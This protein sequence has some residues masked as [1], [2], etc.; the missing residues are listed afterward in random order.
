[1]RE[2]LVGVSALESGGPSVLK[3]TLDIVMD[4]D[5]AALRSL[6][7]SLQNLWMKD[8]PGKNV[9]TVASYLKGSL[10]LLQNCGA[11]PTNTMGLLNDVM[12]SDDYDDFTDYMK[13]I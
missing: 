7:E 9:G 1:M 4:V 10:L 12:S 11:I 8:V 2:G 5:D 13:S 3:K 6:T